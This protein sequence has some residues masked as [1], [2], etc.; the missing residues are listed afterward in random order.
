MK[1]KLNDEQF[2]ALRRYKELIS[3]CGSIVKSDT[4]REIWS[5]WETVRNCKARFTLCSACV[6]AKVKGLNRLMKELADDPRW[7]ET[8]ETVETAEETIEETC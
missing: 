5:I 1:T 6:A 3:H 2:E 4:A 7:K 8:E